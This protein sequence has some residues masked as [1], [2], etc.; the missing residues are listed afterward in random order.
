M[1]QGED[2]LVGLQMWALV[3]LVLAQR[4]MEHGTGIWTFLG[5]F[6]SVFPTLP[7]AVSNQI[8][9]VR[10]APATN[11][12]VGAGLYRPGLVLCDCEWQR[13]FQGIKASCCASPLTKEASGS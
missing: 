2:T 12:L 9:E 8:L 4:S 5:L 3:T 1:S 13:D 6:Q 11:P 7:E 10:V